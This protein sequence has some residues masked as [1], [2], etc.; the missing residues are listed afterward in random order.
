MSRQ[1][2]AHQI[3]LL[4]TFSLHASSLPTQEPTLGKA[5]VFV[6]ALFLLPILAPG[7]LTTIGGIGW[8]PT[9]DLPLWY[10]AALVPK[11]DTGQTNIESYN[12]S[13]TNTGHYLREAWGS[14][15]RFFGSTRRG[16]GDVEGVGV[17]L[18][19]RPS[20]VIV[21]LLGILG[22]PLLSGLL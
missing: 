20:R 9:T 13:A 15:H 19:T 14:S 17:E 16:R 5:L 3:H 4:P 12:S 22:I 11:L 7:F 8:I 10:R 18:I 1:R 2:Q 21:R 6:P